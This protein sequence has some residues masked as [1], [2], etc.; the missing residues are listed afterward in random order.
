MSQESATTSELEDFIDQ[1]YFSLRQ[2]DCASKYVHVKDPKEMNRLV[3]DYA[4]FW[5]DYDISKTTTKRPAP[6]IPQLIIKKKRNNPSPERK[7]KE[8]M[9]KIQQNIVSQCLTTTSTPQV[10]PGGATKENI[11]TRIQEVDGE[12]K[13]LKTFTLVKQFELGYLLASLK[14][15]Y[16]N[17]ADMLVDLKQSLKFSQSYIYQLINFYRVVCNHTSII[18]CQLPFRY[19]I[20]NIKTIETAL[21]QSEYDTM[22]KMDPFDGWNDTTSL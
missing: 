11:Y 2:S 18:F 16:G 3:K 21:K 9:Q 7:I 5:K 15:K 1:R 20:S 13:K 4:K 22:F 12:L 10:I 19:I 14:D 6:P 8:V 17:T